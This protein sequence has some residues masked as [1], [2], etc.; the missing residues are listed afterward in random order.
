M[1]VP[2]SPGCSYMA[3]ANILDVASNSVNVGILQALGGNSTRGE[4]LI[5]D[6]YRRA[7]DELK[8]QPGLKAD[9]IRAD[10]SF[11]QVCRRW[12]PSV[13]YDTHSTLLSTT[14]FCITGTMEKTSSSIR[15]EGLQ[16]QKLTVLLS[17]IVPILYF[18][19]NFRQLARNGPRIRRLARPLACTSKVL[20]G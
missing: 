8:V 19:W 13:R 3:G 5:G 15:P 18:S 6:A 17:R 12:H 20:R 9:G 1:V 16:M 14:G 4:A 2:P 11:N 10:G 7:H